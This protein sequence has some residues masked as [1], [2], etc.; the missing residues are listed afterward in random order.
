VLTEP[1]HG[2]VHD[3]HPGPLKPGGPV[4]GGIHEHGRLPGRQQPVQRSL[5]EDVVGG[6]QHEQRLALNLTLDC[7][8]RRAV[9]VR[10]PVGVH[11]PDPAAPKAAD[12]GRD[13]PG[14]VA[15]HDQD[16]FQAAGEEGPHGP[17]DQ[18]QATQPEKGLGATPVTD[19]SRSDRPAA[20]TI[21]TRGRRDSGEVGW[22]TSARPGNEASRSGG[23][24]DASATRQLPE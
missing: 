22:T 3:P 23:S 2:L 21:P 5:A 7:G 17:L 18:A 6:D 12:D 10:P 16:P 1:D 14:V 8:Q 19:S 24:S 20:S 13:R 4:G 15:D 11:G 9:A